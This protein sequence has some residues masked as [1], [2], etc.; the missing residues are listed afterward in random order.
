MTVTEGVAAP[1]INKVGFFHCGNNDAISAIKSLSEYLEDARECL[2]ECLIV[3]PE[4]FN[5]WPYTD[6]GSLDPTVKN[7]LKALSRRFNVAFVAGLIESGTNGKLGHSCAYLI[8]GDLCD[9]LSCKRGCDGVG[10]YDTCERED[11]PR[12]HRG[13][14]IA[15]LICMDAANNPRTDWS[16]E[17][18]NRE[19]KRFNARRDNII[20]STKD[21]R[22]AFCIPSRMG[23]LDS[24]AVAKYWRGQ[25]CNSVVILANAQSGSNEEPRQPSII[26]PNGEPIF[27][28]CSGGNE[29][30]IISW[31]ISP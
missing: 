19:S 21:H 7:C 20:M 22:V 18:R 2:D 9:V 16:I 12:L 11:A 6:K 3:L 26:Y 8:D 30:R 10:A 14:R 13:I 1:D 29:M 25:L 28:R 24:T 4:A 27:P 15:A 23:Q 5:F 31:P 17:R